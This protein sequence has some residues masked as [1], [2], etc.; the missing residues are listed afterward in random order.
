MGEFSKG[1]ILKL[2]SAFKKQRSYA[3]LTEEVLKAPLRGQQKL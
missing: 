1:D 2:W 3:A